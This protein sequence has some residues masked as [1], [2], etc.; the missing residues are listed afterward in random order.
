MDLIKYVF[1]LHLY[2][3][4]YQTDFELLSTKIPNL[5]LTTQGL[6]KAYNINLSTR[7]PHACC[8]LFNS[9]FNHKQWILRFEPITR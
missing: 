6:F 8:Y 9:L 2:Q 1:N 5:V 4:S 3:F 7:Q